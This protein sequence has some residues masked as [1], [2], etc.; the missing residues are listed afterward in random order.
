M[1]ANRRPRLALF[2]P[3]NPVRSG[4]SDYTEEN[5]PYWSEYAEIDVVVD[6]Y[7][8]SSASVV[9]SHRVLDVAG[10]LDRADDYDGAIYQVGNNYEHCGY[11]IPCMRRAPGVAVVHDYSLSYLM[12]GLTAMRGDIETLDRILQR[13]TGD[14]ARYGAWDLLLSKADPYEVSLAAP[15]VEMARGAIVHN[16]FAADRL[17]RSFPGKRLAT[18]PH[19]TPIREPRAGVAELRRQYGFGPQDEIV[20]SV[21]SVAYNKRLGILV[22]ALAESRDRRPNLKL[23]V[24]GQGALGGEIRGQIARQGLAGRVVATGWVDAEAYLDYIDLSDIVADLRYPTAGETSGSIL[25]A[26]QAGRPIVVSDHGFFAELDES[27]AWKI[28]VGENEREGFREAL[29]T[30]LGDPG[31]RA[32]MGAAGARFARES[33]RREVVAEA[34]MRFVLEALAAADPVVEW[35]LPAAPRARWKRSA[36]AAAYRLG[37]VGYY[38][39]RYGLTDTVRRIFGGTG[40]GRSRVENRP[41]AAVR[42]RR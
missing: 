15:V 37:R 6:S 36:L 10:F 20:A 40:N 34:Y 25:R 32:A 9:A 28:P 23:L 16:R 8:P 30:L 41:A 2:S 17:R 22:D 26:I 24:V 18:I 1:P 21:S 27:F 5:L 42:G 39:R 31:R 12:L 19:P 7:R 11:M 35:E 29:E 3:L 14:G 4:I 13:S 38:S 33:L